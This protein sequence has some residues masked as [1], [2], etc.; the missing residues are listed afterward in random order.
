MHELPLEARWELPTTVDDVAG[1][2]VSDVSEV[3]AQLV[4]AAGEQVSVDQ[5]VLFGNPPVQEQGVPLLNG[6][7]LHLLLE[8]GHRLGRLAGDEQTGGV[9]VEAVDDSGAE[10]TG[11]I[12]QRGE[13]SQQR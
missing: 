9:L 7:V 3:N 6:A 2:R 13:A 10:R 1:H 11:R 4:C 12:A 5:A 8:G